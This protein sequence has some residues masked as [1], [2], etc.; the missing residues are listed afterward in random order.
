MRVQANAFYLEDARR[1]QLLHNGRV[2]PPREVNARTSFKVRA[3]AKRSFD[4]A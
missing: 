1:V 4:A 3:L 2:D